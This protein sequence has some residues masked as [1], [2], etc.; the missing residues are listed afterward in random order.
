MATRY[1]RAGDKF[2][3]VAT[4][5]FLNIIT[6]TTTQ[7]FM[8]TGYTAIRIF[9]S[10]SNTLIWGDVSISTNSGNFLFPLM[11]TEFS[12]VVD[13]FSFYMIADSA[14]SLLTITEYK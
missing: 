2:Y 14:N 10:G 7:I 1:F 3:N 6:T 4:T 8:S 11:A 12:G 5:R 9:N 13:N